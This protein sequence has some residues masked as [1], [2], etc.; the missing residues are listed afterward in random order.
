MPYCLLMDGLAKSRRILEAKSIFEE[1]K[2]KQVKS[3]CLQGFC[4]LDVQEIETWKCPSDDG[5]CYSIMISAFCRS[6]LLKEAKQLARDFEATYDKY[7]LVMLNTML[8]AY[9]RAGEME[10]VMQM[11]RKMDEL[12]IS[13]DWNTFHILI[14]YFCKEKLYLLAYRTME[15]MHNKGHQPEEVMQLS[16]VYHVGVGHNHGTLCIPSDELRV[17]LVWCPPRAT[18]DVDC[19]LLEGLEDY[20][21]EVSVFSDMISNIGKYVELC[22][23]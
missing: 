18:N 17:D 8:C 21:T 15:D 19:G 4:C 13:P 6:G 23:Q 3:A 12:A 7:D 20:S 1:M 14:K 2:K 10:S 22:Q 11:M 9:C 5:Y 16:I